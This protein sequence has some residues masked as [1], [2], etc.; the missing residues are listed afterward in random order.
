MLRV[1]RTKLASVAVS[2][3]G[4]FTLA[5]TGCGMSSVGVEDAAKPATSAAVRGGF[6]GKVFGGQQPISGAYIQLYVAGSGFGN[7]ALPLIPTSSAGTPDGSTQSII[8]TDSNGNFNITYDYTCPSATSQVYIT[9]VGGNPGYTGSVNNTTTALMAALGSCGNLSSATSIQINEVTTV[10]A[11]WALQ[12]FINIPFSNA[13]ASLWQGGGSCTAAGS[14]TSASPYHCASSTPATGFS[15]SSSSTN[16]QG[17]INAFGNAAILANVTTGASPG[18]NAGGTAKVIEYWNV[19]AIANILAACVNV[20]PSVSVA[21]CN[22]LLGNSGTTGTATA[23]NYTSG[24]NPVGGGALAYAAYSESYSPDDTMQAAWLM[25]RNPSTNVSNLFALAGTG[26]FVTA[27]STMTD[28]TIGYNLQG[29]YDGNTTGLASGGQIYSFPAAP[30]VLPLASPMTV[31]F[32][33][34]G[35]AFIANIDTRGPTNGTAAA[36]YNPFITEVDPNGNYVPGGFISGYYESSAASSETPFGGSTTNGTAFGSGNP[37]YTYPIVFDQNNTFYT[38]DAY[39]GYVLAY[40]GASG[41][42]QP[43]AGAQKT[44]PGL[45]TGI[46]ASNAH[47][48][49][50]MV[51]DGNGNLYLIAYTTG[52]TGDPY[53]FN[54]ASGGEQFVFPTTSFAN[55]SV[56]SGTGNNLT[57]GS[58]GYGLVVD[59]TSPTAIVG[60]PF[61][62]TTNTGNCSPTSG[63]LPYSAGY[64]DILVEYGS[65]GTSV[66]SGGSKTLK[67]DSAAAF[68]PIADWNTSSN[69]FSNCTPVTELNPVTSLY[70]SASVVPIAVPAALAVDASNNLWVLNELDAATSSSVYT[71]FPD[72][73]LT[74]IPAPTYSVLSTG[75]VTATF[76]T[77]ISNSGGGFVGAGTD[78]VATYGTFSIAVDGA[79]SVWATNATTMSEFNNNDVA[80]STAST[81]FTGGT[82]SSLKRTAGTYKNIAVDRSGNVWV[83]GASSNGVGINVIIGAATAVT[84]PLLPPYQGALP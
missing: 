81:G 54:V 67:I 26:P 58:N 44:L 42:G 78:N 9:A 27:A 63:A 22:T 79:G 74:K 24:T 3:I 66:G 48:F 75:G 17:L 47:G 21:N 35:N 6:S 2:L 14:G 5:L 76:G 45:A 30:S 28:F 20:N 36:P 8:S 41:A 37:N 82:T 7:G 83:P 23:I 77:P 34:Y 72:Y 73:S 64:G 55:G 33:Q 80:I 11:I 43:A 59:N 32:D 15:I 69:Y 10:A 53:P 51:Y 52:A 18:S 70:N 31:A 56:P 38:Y 25:A 57:V 71:S 50:N 62:Y 61:V 16:T 29:T 4:A 1:Q 12:N 84:T 40:G 46:T 68:S 60:A 49:N 19:N 39:T 65:S 13:A